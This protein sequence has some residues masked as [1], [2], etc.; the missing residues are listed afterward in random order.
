MPIT[1]GFTLSTNAQNSSLLSWG[2]VA[3]DVERG[4][5]EIGMPAAVSGVDNGNGSIVYSL[6]LAK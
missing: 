1:G 5:D 2:A 6:T 3:A 4:L